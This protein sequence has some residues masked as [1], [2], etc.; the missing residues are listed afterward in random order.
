MARDL[1]IFYNESNKLM[2]TML[3]TV[4]SHIREIG[5]AHTQPSTYQCLYGTLKTIR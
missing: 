1:G 3:K 2:K 4:S 5:G